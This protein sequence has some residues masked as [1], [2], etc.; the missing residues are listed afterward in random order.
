MNNICPACRVVS[1]TPTVSRRDVITTQNYIY[2]EYERA[3]A[4]P[5]GQFELYFCRNCGLVFN[6]AFERALMSYDEG[7]TAYI[8]SAVFADYYRETA[9]FLNQKFSLENG[10]VIDIACGKGEFLTALTKMFPTV[11]GL[12]I[13][14][15]FEAGKLPP[16]VNLEF[17][18]DVFREKYITEKPALVL[19]RH[20][21]DQIENPLDFLKS[22]RRS[23]ANYDKVPFFIEVGDLKWILE[24]RSFADFCYERC[25]FFTAESLK[26]ILRL[27]G[28]TVEKIEKAFGSQYLW[29][30][31]RIDSDGRAAAADD[32]NFTDDAQTGEKLTSYSAGEQHLINEMKAKLQAAKSEG[33]ITAVWGMATKGVVFSSLIDEDKSL[34][35]YCIDIN[36]QKFDCFVPHTGHRISSPEILRNSVHAKILIVVMNPNYLDEIA[37]YCQ[38]IGLNAQF[39]D[40]NGRELFV[41]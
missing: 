6:A 15:S 23:L 33:L 13:D 32:L 31:G 29:V 37:D 3:A 7:Y 11:R 36:P 25:S 1:E 41:R 20:A 27:A 16:S 30:Y 28:L 12:G 38:K 24:N 4:A 9:E 21:F 5:V 35:D 8:P 18:S 14:P 34:F 39:T 22:I 2:R 26:N 10:F 40:A 19:C 17:I